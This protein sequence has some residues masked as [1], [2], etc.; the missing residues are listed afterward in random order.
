MMRDHSGQALAFK[1]GE[2]RMLSGLRGPGGSKNFVRVD[3]GQKYTCA[4]AVVRWHEYYTLRCDSGW[5]PL[6][7]SALR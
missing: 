6:P 4:R 7:L 1:A 5:P 3:L 2:R